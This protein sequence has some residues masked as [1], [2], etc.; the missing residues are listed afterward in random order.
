[1]VAPH[2]GE[3]IGVTTARDAVLGRIRDALQDVPAE[4]SSESFPVPRD[5]RR[6]REHP[7]GD[8][9]RFLERVA[10]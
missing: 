8:V 1:M 7:E 9:V 5:Y 6:S 3:G 2:P 4:E 10:D